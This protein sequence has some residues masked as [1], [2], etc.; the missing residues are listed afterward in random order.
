MSVESVSPLSDPI[1]SLWLLKKQ[2]VLL[3]HLERECVGTPYRKRDRFIFTRKITPLCIPPLR[4]YVG[5]S[6]SAAEEQ[7][8]GKPAALVS[9][10][11]SPSVLASGGP[12][13]STVG[14]DMR[15]LSNNAVG[16]TSNGTLKWGGGRLKRGD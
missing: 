9:I 2:P 8:A 15:T 13:N 5:N 6:R 4:V 3:K 7:K 12:V 10:G 14:A 16:S 1:I 11:N